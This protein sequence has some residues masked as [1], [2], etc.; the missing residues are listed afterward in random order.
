MSPSFDNDI[1]PLFRESDRSAMRSSRALNWADLW[2]VVPGLGAG[3]LTWAAEVALDGIG[4][5][6]CSVSACQGSVGIDV[7][8]ANRTRLY[9]AATR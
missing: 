8:R 1:K 2:T 3:E 6:L 9:A 7:S 4:E 5:R